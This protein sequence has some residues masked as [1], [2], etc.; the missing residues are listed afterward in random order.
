[1]ARKSDSKIVDT[2]IAGLVQENVPFVDRNKV[3]EGA[4]RYL[5]DKAGKGGAVVRL[6]EQSIELLMPA[7]PNTLIASWDVA[8][9]VEKE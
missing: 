1:L 4:R 6:L 3:K 9:W 7:I 5:I 8:N 2:A